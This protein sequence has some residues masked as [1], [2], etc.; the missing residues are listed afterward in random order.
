MKKKSRNL[1]LNK[2]NIAK[3]SNPNIIIGG[4]GSATCPSVFTC[5]TIESTCNTS[6]PDPVD[7]TG[8]SCVRC[9]DQPIVG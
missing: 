7:P 1:K 5:E 9:D 2:K 8:S 6:L 4:T 3:L